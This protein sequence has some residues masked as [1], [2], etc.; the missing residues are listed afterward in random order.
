MY[1][2]TLFFV[3]VYFYYPL[4]FTF[5]PKLDSGQE[6]QNWGKNDPYLEGIEA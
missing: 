6:D 2:S 1:V 5:L 4:F 3:L